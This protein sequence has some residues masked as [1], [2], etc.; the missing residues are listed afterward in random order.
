MISSTKVG[1]EGHNGESNIIVVIDP[2]AH[3]ILEA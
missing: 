1:V 2:A 3:L